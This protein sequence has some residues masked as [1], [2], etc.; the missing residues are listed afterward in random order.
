MTAGAQ[1]GSPAAPVAQGFD[2]LPLACPRCRARLAASGAADARCG[3]CGGAFP[4]RDGLLD[5]RAGRVG[6]PGYDPHYFP[7]LAAV[8]RDHYWFKTRREV[9]RDVLRDAV[10]DLAG[11]RSSTSAAAAA[12]SSR[13]SAR[14]ACR[15]RG[16]A[17]RTRRASRSCAAASR[18]RCCWSTRG[19]S[20]R[21][22]RGSRC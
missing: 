15:W 9:V 1:P 12:G 4:L 3:A 20:R 16:P 6:A 13:S 21:S 18:R 7:T 10:P 2:S 19:A 11:G 5:L 17:T 8:E 14:A 22:R